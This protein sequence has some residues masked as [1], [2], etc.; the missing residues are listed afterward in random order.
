MTKK[1]LNL[2]HED[3]EEGGTWC[4]IYADHEFMAF[5]RNENFQSTYE[6][7][8]EKWITK[9]EKLIGHCLDG[10]QNTNGYSYD[11]AHDAFVAADKAALAAQVQS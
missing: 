1:E 7:K 10:D 2:L 11:Y 9:A 4:D 3:D 5:A 6:S 8:W